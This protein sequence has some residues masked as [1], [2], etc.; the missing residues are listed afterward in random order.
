M[1]K[2]SSKGSQKPVA[3]EAQ[4]S[5]ESHGKSK[6]AFSKAM[7]DPLLIE[8]GIDSW[9]DLATGRDALQKYL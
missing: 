4:K 5:E 1:S 6:N 7:I 8:I 3:K 2:G 9:K